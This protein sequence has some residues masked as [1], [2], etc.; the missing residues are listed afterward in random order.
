M[1]AV[2]LSMASRPNIS[3]YIQLRALYHRQ[4]TYRSCDHYSKSRY[5]L[6]FSALTQPCNE[7][8]LIII[9]GTIYL[10]TR[11]YISLVGFYDGVGERIE[12]SAW[13]AYVQS[14]F[15]TRRIDFDL[16]EAFLR[17]VTSCYVWISSQQI[18]F[19]S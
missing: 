16:N 1:Q 6:F 5:F 17:K 7:N 19:F 10:Y 3:A 18:N 2:K 15:I 11:I 9:I 8:I 4:E 12:Y 13:N 14:M